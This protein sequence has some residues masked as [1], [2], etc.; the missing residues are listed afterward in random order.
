MQT[1]LILPT[2]AQPIMESDERFEI[3]DAIPDRQ[4]AGYIAIYTSL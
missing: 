3:T 2:D 4:R 1:N